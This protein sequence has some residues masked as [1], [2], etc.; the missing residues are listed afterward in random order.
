MEVTAVVKNEG[1]LGMFDLVFNRWKEWDVWDANRYALSSVPLVLSVPYVP[2]KSAR[3]SLAKSR[4]HRPA[5]SGFTIVETIGAC[6]ILGIIFSMTVPMFLVIAR[7]RHSTE[8]RQFA[9]QHAV[10]LLEQATARRWSELEPGRLPV[11]DADADLATV[12]PGLERSLVVK[13]IDGSPESRQIVASIRWQSRPGQLVSP[14]E[15][16]AWIYSTG[17]TP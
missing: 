16:S 10:N 15:I 17:E 9:L 7:E 14:I 5:R 2:L 3:S 12:L 13:S 4:C 8:Q 11:P 6:V 1:L